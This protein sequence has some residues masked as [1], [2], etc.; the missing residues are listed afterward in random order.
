MVVRAAKEATKGTVNGTVNN[1]AEVRAFKYQK[2][3]HTEQ[4]VPVPKSIKHYHTDRMY[5]MIS[6]RVRI[7]KNDKMHSWHTKRPLKPFG[8]SHINLMRIPPA[9]SKGSDK[10]APSCRL[11]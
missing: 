1:A 3:L 5:I 7:E 2:N 6:Y 9:I 11:V 10:P 8:P 4:A